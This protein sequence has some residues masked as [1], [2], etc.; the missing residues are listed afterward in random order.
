MELREFAQRILYGDSLEAKL[1]VPEEITDH[2]PGKPVSLPAFPT[3]PPGLR[4]GDKALEKT[5]PGE[6]RKIESEQ[7]RARVLHHFANH[8]LLAFELMALTLL[9]FPD[10]PADFRRGLYG[11]ILEEQTHFRLYC[12]RML[13]LGLTFGELAVNDFFWKHV[14]DITTPVDF[15]VRMSL[16]FEQANLDYALYYGEAFRRLGDQESSEIMDVVLRDEI[17]HVKNGVI[18]FREFRG[19]TSGGIGGDW[20]EYVRRLPPGLDPMRARGLNFSREVRRKAGLSEEFIRELEVYS[21]SRGRPPRVFLFTVDHEDTL[22]NSGGAQEL[23]GLLLNLNSDLEVLP[24]FL[25]APEDSLLISARPSR[26]FLRE[27]S[28]AGFPT[29]EFI[30]PA[31]FTTRLGERKLWD[32][33]PWGWNPRSLQVM[34]DLL[35]EVVGERGRRL[36]TM[37]ERTETL[38]VSKNKRTFPVF[39]RTLNS[40]SY[41]ANL[42]A[43]LGA[44]PEF[45]FYDPAIKGRVAE[46]QLDLTNLIEE[47]LELTGSCLLK[48]PY[49]ASGRNRLI[50]GRGRGPA[51]YQKNRIDNMLARYGELIVE[52]WLSRKFDFSYL[53]EVRDAGSIKGVGLTRLL[54]DQAGRYRGGVVGKLFDGLSPAEH[55]LLRG[56]GDRNRSVLKA[57]EKTGNFLG[58][59]LFNLGYR[60]P[61]GLD[62]FVYRKFSGSVPGLW[63]TSEFSLNPLVEINLR[64]TMGNIALQLAGRMR[65]G[66]VGLFGLLNLKD[67][68]AAGF[69]SFFSFSETMRKNFPLTILRNPAPL[70]EEGFMFVTDPLQARGHI[71]FFSVAPDISGCLKPLEGFVEFNNIPGLA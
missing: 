21:R 49:G 6:L 19:D 64:Y 38:N 13:E 66:R 12:E 71:A 43:E 55:N 37:L 22:A 14:A 32:L 53:F 65:G 15:V 35:G 18:W 7:A 34:G 2:S 11:T 39:L 69:D 17:G 62:A 16:T 68:E 44:V 63:P 1:I 3:R 29:P 70:V 52:P 50:L 28:E 67:I 5:P 54:T 33:A 48:A 41:C 8:E 46:N 30:T 27:L 60:G 47:T 31:D 26:E 36:R 45:D 20:D 61:V 40:K 56:A 51:P 59:T 24:A 10:A 42:Q 57:L 9:R 23:S 4:L 58:R 25:C